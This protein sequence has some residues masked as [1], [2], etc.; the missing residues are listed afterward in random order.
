MKTST[1]LIG[2]KLNSSNKLDVS[3]FYMAKLINLDA[4]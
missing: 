2:L 1:V 4:I 3:N